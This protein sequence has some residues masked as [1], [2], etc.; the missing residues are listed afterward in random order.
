LTYKRI[1]AKLE[2]ISLPKLKIEK[3]EFSEMKLTPIR[4]AGIETA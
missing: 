2:E 4:S 1:N 3:D